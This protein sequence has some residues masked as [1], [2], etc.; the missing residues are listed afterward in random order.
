MRIAYDA[1]AA[2][3]QSAGVG[4]YSRELLREL[5]SLNANDDV[6]VVCAANP[7][8]ARAVM[9]Q[10]PPGAMRELRRIP[11]GY[12]ATTIAWQRLRI[13]I[14]VESFTRPFEVFHATDFV[15]PPSRQPIVTTVHDLS[16]LR[17]PELGEPRLVR[18][19]T[20]AVPRTLA[21]SQRIIAVSASVAADLVD[22]YPETRDRVVAIPNG[23]RR[24][25]VATI[26]PASERATVL[27]VGTI[28]PRKNHLGVL[29]A[30]RLVRDRVRDAE[31]LIVGRAGWR[32][33]EIVEAI[34][35]AEAEGW[36]RWLPN[37]GD[38]DLAQAY[39]SSTIFVYPSWY[40][41]FGLP[42]LEAMSYG[43]PVVAG[44]IP[45][46]REAAGDAASFA[47]PADEIAI[48]DQISALLEDT[49]LPA[50]LRSRGLARVAGYS[51]RNTAEQTRRV[52]EQAKRGGR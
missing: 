22:A 21:R 44:D 27:M 35:S 30:M 40:E 23:V 12:R 10:L 4:R 33:A 13:P 15:A 51:W 42:I 28:E 8:A 5:V 1:T 50:D 20:S 24:P 9:D 37:A 14:P 31:L 17:V 32:S 36:V 38:L 46:L 48:A 2:A 34:G 43:L 3:T 25:P 47:D 39:A 16:Y 49:D 41:G 19:L 11:G 7:S 52:Y 6:Q 26:E 18:Y 29:A 45:A